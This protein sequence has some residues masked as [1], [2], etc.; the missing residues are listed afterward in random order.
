MSTEHKIHNLYYIIDSRKELVEINVSLDDSQGEYIENW[1]L[2]L[3][4]WVNNEEGSPIITIGNFVTKRND[5]LIGTIG[6]PESQEA[7]LWM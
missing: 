4:V 7:L 1:F 3:C 5:T 2:Q 6:W